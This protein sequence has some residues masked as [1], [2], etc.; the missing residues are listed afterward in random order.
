[1]GW[2]VERISIRCPFSA[3]SILGFAMCGAEGVGHQV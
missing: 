2:S 1:V 3:A